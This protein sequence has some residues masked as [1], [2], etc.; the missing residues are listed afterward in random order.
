MHRTTTRGRELTEWVRQ[1]KQNQSYGALPPE[2]QAFVASMG[3]SALRSVV[4]ADV[5]DRVACIKRR[6]QNQ[7]A[8][9][10][11]QRARNQRIEEM[12]GRLYATQVH[13]ELLGAH[14]RAMSEYAE[15]L[16]TADGHS[17]FS[18][19]WC[20]LTLFQDVSAAKFQATRSCSSIES[21]LFEGP[22]PLEILED[23]PERRDAPDCAAQDIGPM[24][25]DTVGGGQQDVR[26]DGVR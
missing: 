7:R 21:E 9:E 5:Q 16:S 4:A 23:E 17:I 22:L 26:V 25:A 10:T 3:L 1:S 24:P 11:R 19:G 8:L 2:L 13:C 6:E 14:S 20:A 15:H 18:P 12:R